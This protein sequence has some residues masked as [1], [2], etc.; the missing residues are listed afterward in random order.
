MGSP[1]SFTVLGGGLSGLS[2][3]FHLSRRFPARTGTRITLL[4]KS[5]RLG[6]WVQSE[7]VRVKDKHGHE[8]EILLESGPRTLR[9]ASKAVLE[10]IHLL[11]LESSLLTVPRNA[12][13]ARNRFLHVPGSKGL[14]T[15][16]GSLPALLV[17]PLAKI[18]VPAMYRDFRRIN[19]TVLNA[20][21]P[22]DE[23]VDAFFTR[24]FGPE[25]ART[26]GSALIHGIYATDSRLLS[27][28]AAF[29]AVC[30]LEE[31]GNGS[32]VRGALREMMSSLRKRKSQRKTVDEE[33]EAY[34]MGE[35]AH[36]MKGVSV[37]SFRDGM[38]TLT[39]AMASRL[40]QQENV[41]IIHGDGAA[42]LIKTVDGFQVIT[43]SGREIAT[44]QLISALPLPLLHRLLT[45]SNH[46]SLAPSSN[47]LS[48]SHPATPS[49]QRRLPPP[50]FPHP[51]LSARSGIPG[52]YEAS[53]PHP[54]IVPP[55]SSH[56]STSLRNTVPPLPHVLANPSS[57]VTVVNIVFPPSD[58]P[59]HPE[60]FGY[61]IPRPVSDYPSQ[62]T[63]LG[64]LGT[65]FDS[66]SLN[67]QD[68][69]F[70]ADRRSPKFTKVTVMLGGPYG[71]PSPDPSSAEFLPALLG[72]LQ[73]HLGHPEPLPEPCLVRVRRHPDCIP[74]LTVGHVARMAELREAVREKM[75]QGAAVIGAGVGGVS[76]GDC[77]E[78]GRRVALEL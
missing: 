40:R 12:P 43:S 34:D 75:G 14:L 3:A 17:S 46:T 62:G 27:V 69:S 26:F 6:G 52:R 22:N 47:P 50:P 11:N 15:I 24:H 8:A 74:T 28:R 53:N 31:S 71:P 33:A 42:S 41:E 9:P 35:V 68:I 73:Q 58:T 32:V 48:Q 7:R 10:I 39:D 1:R 16:P 56:A 76:V 44:S 20:S 36:L 66:C 59:I 37:Y 63:T 4:E 70:S 30:R 21:S 78:S 57:S 61:L 5:S 49:V 64:M 19:G 38:Q 29:S 25:F 55:A 23:S 72:A 51:A 18:L 60:G 77:I 67:G 65:V 45:T 54:N 13:A 2:A